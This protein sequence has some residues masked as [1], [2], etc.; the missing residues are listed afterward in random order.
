M[1]SHSNIK[2]KISETSSLWEDPCYDHH[3]PETEMADNVRD[4]IE[5]MNLALHEVIDWIKQIEYRLS[6][7]YQRSQAPF[8]RRLYC[9]YMHYGQ[10]RR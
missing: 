2:I 5:N 3:H 1:I 9:N 7:F 4:H 10:I 8:Q 6:T